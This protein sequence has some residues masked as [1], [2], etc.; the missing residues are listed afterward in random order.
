[1][2]QPG[3]PIGPLR[4]WP[5]DKTLLY[6][7]PQLTAPKDRRQRAEWWQSTHRLSPCCETVLPAN[8]ILF[9]NRKTHR[10]LHPDVAVMLLH[11]TGCHPLWQGAWARGSTPVGAGQ[12]RYRRT[13]CAAQDGAPT[14]HETLG[15][16]RLRRYPQPG[17][18]QTSCYRRGCLG[19][20]Y[21]T[22]KWRFGC[23]PTDIH[24]PVRVSLPNH[25]P[26]T[27]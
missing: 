23:R 11:S 25:A 4:H 6:L 16:R 20:T 22:S 15:A 18:K 8:R 9:A 27:E 14:G 21:T 13:Y 12:H 24:P 19:Q 3:Q 17:Y 7:A 10:L 26:A 2:R 1:M 5:F